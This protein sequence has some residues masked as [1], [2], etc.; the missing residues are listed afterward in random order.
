MILEFFRPCK[1]DSIWKYS[2]DEVEVRKKIVDFC[3]S[4]FELMLIF[5][6]HRIFTF[7]T[8]RKN[9]I[10]KKKKKEREGMPRM[11]FVKIWGKNFAAYS[12]TLLVIVHWFLKMSKNL[13]QN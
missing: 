10:K 5:K 12:S 4:S 2:I 6:V 8:K 13:K 7:L 9:K 11:H 3:E 1:F